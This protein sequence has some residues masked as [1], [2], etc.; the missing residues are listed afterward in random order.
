MTQ[1]GDTTVW[2]SVWEIAFLMSVSKQTVYRWLHG[3]QDEPPIIPRDG[4]IRL[5]HSGQIRI[6]GDIPANLQKGDYSPKG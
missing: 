3:T 6:R 5:P 1:E 2:Y 4:W